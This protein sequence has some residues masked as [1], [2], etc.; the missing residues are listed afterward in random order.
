LGVRLLVTGDREWSDRK[1]M[2]KVI[3]SIFKQ[4]GGTFT[5]IHGNARGADKMAGEIARELGLDVLVFPAEWDKYGKAAG[6]IRN[7][8]M[9]DEGQPDRAVAFHNNLWRGKGTK[10]MVTRLKK[11]GIRC[12]LACSDVEELEEL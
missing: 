9:I 5:V 11:H 6:P 1:T 10:D 7:Q 3:Y 4:Y 2:M 12:S 8:Q